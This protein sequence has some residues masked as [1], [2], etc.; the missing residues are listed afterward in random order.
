MASTV[1]LSSKYQIVIPREAREALSLSAGDELLVLC[2]ADRVDSTPEL[3]WLSPTMRLAQSRRDRDDSFDRL[4]AVNE[5]AM[6]RRTRLGPRF[7]PSRC[8]PS[9]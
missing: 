7:S 2:K 9:G 4:G 8:V 6:R 1:T 3:P 5:R